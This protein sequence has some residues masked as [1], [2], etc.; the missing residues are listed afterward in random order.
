MPI[1]SISNKDVS[2]ARSSNR[3]ARK[4]GYQLH[5]LTSDLGSD[6][7]RFVMHKLLKQPIL[8]N[9]MPKCVTNHKKLL[10]CAHVCENISQAWSTLKYAK[11][12]DHHRAPNVV[13][14]SVV[15]VD[16]HIS[17]RG[18]VSCLGLN[19]RTVRR[20]FLRRQALIAQEGGLWAKSDRQR[21]FD[22][23]SPSS[24]SIIIQ[25]WT[26]ETRVS[27]NKKDVV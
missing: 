27:P 18:L 22:C 10:Q 1:S 25:W 26:N 11:G 19:R 23:L 4:L 8:K 24:V 7:Q 21:R 6:Y 20:G 12:C 17:A 14:A 16:G 5:N 9:A 13:E 2:V 15:F 3:L